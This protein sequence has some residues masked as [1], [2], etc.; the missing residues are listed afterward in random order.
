M[1]TEPWSGLSQHGG[2]GADS[3]AAFAGRMFFSAFASAVSGL[4][5]DLARAIWRWTEKKAVD[6]FVMIGRCTTECLF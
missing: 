4:L 5:N 6:R 2:R 3:A 1:R